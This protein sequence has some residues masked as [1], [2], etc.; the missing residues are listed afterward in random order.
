MRLLNLA[1]F[2]NLISKLCLELLKLLRARGCVHACLS[3]L[4]KLACIRTCSLNN[5]VIKHRSNARLFRFCFSESV[6]LF[7]FLIPLFI[8]QIII[9]HA[10][11][12]FPN[13]SR[14]ERTCIID[15]N[16]ALPG[17]QDPLPAIFSISVNFLTHF[18]SLLNGG[19]FPTLNPFA[20]VISFSFDFLELGV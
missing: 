19:T 8:S 17:L 20:I 1:L 14:I 11:V 4:V 10:L 12:S 13:L 5:G 16:F 15:R 9:K 2:P 3:L 7:S 18:F 6:Y